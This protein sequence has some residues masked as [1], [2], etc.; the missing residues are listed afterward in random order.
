MNCLSNLIAWSPGLIVSTSFIT[1]T[2]AF[3]AAIAIG[4]SSIRL[5]YFIGFAAGRYYSI[6]T[7][8]SSLSRAE[9]ADP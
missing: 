3:I 6:S 7:A 9:P 2:G 8:A 4:F 5:D 1:G